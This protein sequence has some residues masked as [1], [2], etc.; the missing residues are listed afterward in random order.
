[1]NP[2]SFTADFLIDIANSAPFPLTV[3]EEQ[4]WQTLTFDARDGWQVAIFYDGAE[5]DYVDH[6]IAPDG[7]VIEPFEWPSTEQD[8]DAEFVWGDKERICFWRP[9]VAGGS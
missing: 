9:D 7:T 5:F 6:F 4:W 2:T 3:P 8:E 1:M